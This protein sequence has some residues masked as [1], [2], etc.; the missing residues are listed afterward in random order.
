MKC[1]PASGASCDQHRR[2]TESKS[3]ELKRSGK[4]SRTV[5]WGRSRSSAEPNENGKRAISLRRRP[6]R[7]TPSTSSTRDLTIVVSTTLP[8]SVVSTLPVSPWREVC[9]A[10]PNFTLAASASSWNSIRLIEK[11]VAS[12]LDESNC[13]RASND[14]STRAKDRDAAAPHDKAAIPAATAIQ[15]RTP[16]LPDSERANL[17]GAGDHRVKQPS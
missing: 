10:S 4:R 7:K 16:L 6:T 1:A 5:S 8:S 14:S 9:A 13:E 15:L 3:L 12:A 11:L 17:A 2:S